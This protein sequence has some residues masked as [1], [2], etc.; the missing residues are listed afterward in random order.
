MIKSTAAAE[1]YKA[2]AETVCNRY[3]GLNPGE[4]N[5]WFT[6]FLPEAP[7]RILDVG[8]GSG[9]D[10]SWMTNLGHHVTAVEPSAAMRREALHY[11]GSEYIEWIDDTLPLLP[12]MNSRNERFDFILLSAVWMHV[13]PHLRSIAMESL[14]NLLKPTGRIAISLRMGGAEPERGIHEVTIEE[15]R[16][17]SETHGLSLRTIGRLDDKLGRQQVYWVNTVLFGH[18]AD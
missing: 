1:W 9:R 14:S 16:S 10:A 8:S 18:K 4:L 7:A 6:Q 5:A 3:E 17:L 11:H 2:N 13:A 15:L 12:R